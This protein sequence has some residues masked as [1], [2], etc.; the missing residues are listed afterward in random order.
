MIKEGKKEQ[1]F[2]E[3]QHRVQLISSFLNTLK[4]DFVEREDYLLSEYPQI[5]QIDLPEDFEDNFIES[6][7]DVPG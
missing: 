5:S 4:E 6:L 2:S 1:S 3:W 7:P